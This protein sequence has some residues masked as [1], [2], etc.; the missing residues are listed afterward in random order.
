M[1]IEIIFDINTKPPFL[2]VIY[3][4][5]ITIKLQFKSYKSIPASFGNF[6]V[7][8]TMSGFSAFKKGTSN[9]FLW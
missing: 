9:S 8:N 6:S 5:I 3:E 7:I 1:A 4:G 2:M